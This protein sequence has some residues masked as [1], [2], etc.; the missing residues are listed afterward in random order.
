MPPPKPESKSLTYT[1]NNR[2]P[3]TEPRGTPPTTPSHSDLT[4]PIPTLCLPRN[5]HAPIQVNTA[6]PIPRAS[7]PPTSPSCGTASKALPKSRHTTSQSPPPPTAPTMLEQKV[8]KFVKHERPPAKPC[9]DP[10]T[11][12]CFSR[13]RRTVFATTDSSNSPTTDAR[14]ISRQPDA[15]DPSPLPKTGPTLATLHDS[16]TPPDSI[17]PSNM[18]D[19]GSESSSP[20]SP[21]TP[22]NTPPG[23]GDLFGPSPSKCLITPSMETDKPANQSPSPPTQTRSAEGTLL[24][25][26]PANT[27]TKYSSKIP[28][29]SP[30]PSA[31]RPVSDFNGPILSLVLVRYN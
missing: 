17:D 2:G 9:F 14:P 28:L 4:P 13:W 22:A 23:P 8:S 24:S 6:P 18:V 25:S 15:S 30:S 1:T 3:R 29:I 21:S 27:D 7:I 26:S 12:L 31:T 19:S 20:H 10:P 16:G 5:S 11:N